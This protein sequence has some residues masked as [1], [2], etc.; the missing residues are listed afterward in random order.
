[1]WHDDSLLWVRGK[2]NRNKKYKYDS[3]RFLLGFQWRIIRGI[4]TLLS[5][6]DQAQE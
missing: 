3:V 4:F 5:F 6:L 2:N 1:M